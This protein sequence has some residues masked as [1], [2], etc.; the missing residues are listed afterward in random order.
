MKEKIIIILLGIILLYS[1]L[2]QCAYVEGITWSRF[3]GTIQ[4]IYVT[5]SIL[6][7]HHCLAQILSKVVTDKTWKVYF[8]TDLHD[9]KYKWED[10]K[11]ETYMEFR[12]HVKAVY[13]KDQYST[14]DQFWYHGRPG[15]SLTFVDIHP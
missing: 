3:G 8:F 6:D 14:R 4:N 7:C 2:G 1:S 5:P 10:D 13:K 15:D 12:N 9:I 11:P